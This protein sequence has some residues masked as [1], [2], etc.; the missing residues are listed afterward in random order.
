[1]PEE[2]DL[3]KITIQERINRTGTPLYEIICPRCDGVIKGSTEN[4]QD[5]I[6]ECYCEKCGEEFKAIKALKKG[7]KSS[8]KELSTKP[9]EVKIKGEKPPRLREKKSLPE[10]IPQLRTKRWHEIICPE[11][12]EIVDDSTKGYRGL[13]KEY[14]CEGCDTKFKVGEI[15]TK[16]DGRGVIRN[17]EVARNNILR[18]IN[19]RGPI[20]AQ[21]LGKK[22]G[23]CK[24]TTKKILDNL[25]EEGLIK[26]VF[27]GW[28]M[29]K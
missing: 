29:V 11:C 24:V 14:T 10:V 3:R 12:G 25:E 22:V 18:E 28:I 13:I 26:H 23:S 16:K 5:L 4:P 20:S 8:G 9:G 27:K 2:K 7:K 21:E 19:L 15:P 17:K 6:G 1:M